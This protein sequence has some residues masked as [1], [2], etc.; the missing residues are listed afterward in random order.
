MEHPMVNANSPPIR[1]TNKG[2][3]YSRLP[4]T[5]RGLR[6]KYIAYKH[7]RAKYYTLMYMRVAYTVSTPYTTILQLPLSKGPAT[8]QR[9]YKRYYLNTLYK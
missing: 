2:R 6:P 1:R 7:L 3:I 8:R 4:T 5:D 9:R